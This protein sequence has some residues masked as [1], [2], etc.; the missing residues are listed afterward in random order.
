MLEAIYLM[1][2][3]K[4]SS[5]VVLSIISTFLTVISVYFY[6]LNEHNL[7]QNNL[8]NEKLSE[9]QQRLDL[10]RSKLILL[11]NKITNLKSDFQYHS[12]IPHN[13]LYEHYKKRIAELTKNNISKIVSVEPS[14]SGKWFATN[15]HFI[16]P[17]LMSV[18]YEDGHYSFESKIKIINPL[19]NIRFEVVK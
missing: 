11:E 5:N 14:F 1:S 13:V 12:S 18:V 4:I 2:E 3:N 16:D 19:E 9:Y 6:L 17:S 10:D 8:L 15:I 7:K